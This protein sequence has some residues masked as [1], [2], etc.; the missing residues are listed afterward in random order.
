MID[1]AVPRDID[2]NVHRLDGVY[3]YDLDAL[4]SMAERSLE[5][6]KQEAAGCDHLIAKHVVEFQTWLE[7]S[8]P[9]MIGSVAME[10]PPS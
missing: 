1:V 4:Q 2:P 8:A 3:V 7:R 5:A 6:R 9:A 10:L